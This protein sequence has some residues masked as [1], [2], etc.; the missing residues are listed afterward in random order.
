MISAGL[1]ARLLPP[2]GGS[3][4]EL[5]LQ[6]LYFFSFGF[7]SGLRPRRLAASSR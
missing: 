1:K 4:L 6:H 3:V 7:L 5:R 2:M